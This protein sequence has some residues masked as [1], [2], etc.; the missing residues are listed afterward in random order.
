MEVRKK[1]IAAA[2]LT[3]LC[4]AGQSLSAPDQIIT[5]ENVGEI[6]TVPL[7][8]TMPDGGDFTNIQVLLELPDGIKPI[9]VNEDDDGNLVPD[10]EEFDVLQTDPQTGQKVRVS[11]G[12]YTDV[13]DDVV[14]LGRCWCPAMTYVDNFDDPDRVFYTIVG[15]NVKKLSNTHNP[16]QFVTFYVTG[17][18]MS[19][20]VRPLKAYCKYTQ[21]DDQSFTVGTPE[22][23]ADVCYITFEFGPNP[24]DAIDD[25]TVS[26]AEGEVRYYNAA[27]VASSTPFEGVNIVVT[28]LPDGSQR[29]E[30][31]VR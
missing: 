7:T 23:L 11:T 4:S 27:G 14:Q 20:G 13:G 12:W 5:C 21:Y 16:N 15:V 3:G 22:E 19:T 24:P 10:S 2:L 26:P 30:K 6:I 8:L 25:V 29:V 1:L 9:K 17:E 18:P 31:M 28:S